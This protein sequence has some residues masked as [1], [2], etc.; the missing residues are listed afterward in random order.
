MDREPDKNRR[1]RWGVQVLLVLAGGLLVAMLG[2]FAAEQ[3]AD[4]FDPVVNSRSA[5]ANR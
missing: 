1:R 5:H 2:W 4:V 3:T